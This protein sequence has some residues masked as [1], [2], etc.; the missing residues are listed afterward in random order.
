MFKI[1]KTTRNKKFDGLVGRVHKNKIKNSDFLNEIALS[2]RRR[3]NSLIA[4]YNEAEDKNIEKLIYKAIELE[5]KAAIDLGFVLEYE[6]FT[7]NRVRTKTTL[8]IKRLDKIYFNG[9]PKAE[10]EI[11][12][13]KKY[14]TTGI[15]N[16]NNNNNNTEIIDEKEPI[17]PVTNDKVED[18]K[19]EPIIIKSVNQVDRNEPLQRNSMIISK[20]E[21]I[22]PKKDGV[23]FI[24]IPNEYL[25]EFETCLMYG[26]SLYV[27]GHEYLPDGSPNRWKEHNGLV[28]LVISITKDRMRIRAKSSFY[29]YSG[30][31]DYTYYFG[32]NK[33]LDRLIMSQFV[34]PLCDSNDI[35]KKY[36]HIDISISPRRNYLNKIR[37][38]NMRD[39]DNP[40]LYIGKQPM[41]A[42][43]EALNNDIL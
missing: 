35:V 8:P 4:L 36:S 34:V 43:V 3:I 40:K 11:F 30:V 39:F 21:G 16:K 14:T 24:Y 23:K 26:T 10:S 29:N 33:D 22:K 6:K 2:T 41:I 38:S 17:K 42:E 25:T 15:K 31:E 5:E 20:N 37:N 13:N 7:S 28:G 27:A 1:D 19:G 18:P 32:N 12:F 9:D